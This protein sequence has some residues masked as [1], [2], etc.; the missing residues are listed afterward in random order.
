MRC[1][2]GRRRTPESS[3]S[4]SFSGRGVFAGCRAAGG[5]RRAPFPFADGPCALR[6]PPGRAGAATAK[7]D[8]VG[9]VKRKNPGPVDKPHNRRFIHRPPKRRWW[10]TGGGGIVGRAR[11]GTTSAPG[12]TT[13]R[14]TRNVRDQGDHRRQHHQEP[15]Y[16]VFTT[17]LEG[18][19]RGAGQGGTGPSV[20]VGCGDPEGT[21][22]GTLYGAR[23]AEGRGCLV[24][25]RAEKKGC[26]VSPGGEA[27]RSNVQ[28]SC[29]F[30]RLLTR[31]SMGSKTHARR[32]RRAIKPVQ[33][34]C[35]LQL[36]CCLV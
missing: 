35:F 14:G 19:A 23:G 21:R 27:R 15:V 36:S 31:R 11:P 9:V 7:G 16:P 20:P 22:L 24:A 26:L 12:T 8:G 25:G 4:R 28:V 17:T 3:A 13:R 30:G 18:G 10:P 6:R 33:G 2:S 34:W 29:C 1:I 5:S 32:K